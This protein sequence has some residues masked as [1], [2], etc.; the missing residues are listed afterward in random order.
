M[1]NYHNP[2][3]KK[4]MD[5]L[6]TPKRISFI[7]KFNIADDNDKYLF[8]GF[9]YALSQTEVCK[10]IPASFDYKADKRKAINNRVAADLKGQAK[11]YIPAIKYLIENFEDLGTYRLKNAYSSF[12]CEA[13]PFL[14]K[15]LKK[16]VVEL[17]IE[18]EYKSIRNKAY[19]I[20]MKDWSQELKRKLIISLKRHKDVEA[21]LLVANHFRSV[22]LKSF[23]N[24][25]DDLL[26][27]A[28]PDFD[29][30]TKVARNKFYAK[31][32][33]WIPE[34]ISKIKFDDPVSYLYIQS[35]AK[36]QIDKDLALQLYKSNPL[37]YRFIPKLLGQAGLWKELLGLTK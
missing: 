7:K 2:Q 35:Y 24:I 17:F 14:E 33:K 1:S 21:A 15:S 34:K 11:S 26:S 18:S 37:G 13:H 22:D 4:K 19:K 23:I 27:E 16:Q 3:R 31:V 8:R 10:L 6:S 32:Y 5:M 9:I 12:L 20:L 29:F 28:G 36:Q 30:E 25:I